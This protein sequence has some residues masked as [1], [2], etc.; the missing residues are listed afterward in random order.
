MAKKSFKDYTALSTILARTVLHNLP[1]VFFL[2][3]LA[4]IYI[5]NVHYA[6]NK[7]REIKTLQEEVKELRWR[8]MSLKSE[9]MY[10]SKRS[11]VADKVKDLNLNGTGKRPKKIIVPK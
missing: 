2:G 8:Y 10:N 3:L 5:A 6:E 1:F 11:E 7:V 9:L 4:S